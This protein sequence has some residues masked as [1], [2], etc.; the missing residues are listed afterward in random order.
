MRI[1]TSTFQQQWLTA[2]G[3]QQSALARLQTQI[4]SGKRIKTAADDPL[5]AA[6][7]VRLQQGLDRIDN[8][9]MNADTVERRLNLEESTLGRVTDALDRVRELAIQAGGAARA[10][11]ARTAIADEAREILDGLLDLANTQDAEGRFL[12]SGNQVNSQPF[13]RVAGSITYFGDEG[14]RSERIGDNRLVQEGD[15]GS[16]VF[17]KI[18]NGNGTFSVQPGAANAGASNYNSAIVADISSWIPDRKSVV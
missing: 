4:T 3:D 1:A 11:E 8:Y 7:M 9:S 17:Q 10:P 13:S 5:G 2:I 18:R 16:Q 6:Q 12:F 15:P 14:T